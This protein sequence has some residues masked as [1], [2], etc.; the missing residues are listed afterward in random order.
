[1]SSSAPPPI[2]PGGVPAAK[3]QESRGVL[4]LGLVGCAALSVVAI[5][6][7]VL[8]MR[9][10]PELME[11]LLGATEAQVVAAIEP[12]VPAPDREAFRKEYAAF[13]EAAKSGKARPETI[14]S[15]QKKIV[16][17]LKDGKVTAEEL[18]SLTDALRAIPTT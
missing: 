14:Q 13:V 6:G 4:K 11:K 2:A 3:D 10:A 9:K 8:F 1:M 17:A 5:V 7:M 16:E 15:L 12:D 18:R